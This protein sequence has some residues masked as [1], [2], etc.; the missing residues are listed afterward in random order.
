MKLPYIIACNIAGALLGWFVIAPALQPAGT[1][2]IDLYPQGPFSGMYVWDGRPF[3]SHCGLL[4]R[5]DWKQGFCISPP[6]SA[7]DADARP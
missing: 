5:M 2:V 4:E 7:E 1:P 6:L 3:V